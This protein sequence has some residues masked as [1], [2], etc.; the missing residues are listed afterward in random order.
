MGR[1]SLLKALLGS[2]FSMAHVSKAGISRRWDFS[3]P[4]MATTFRI[5]CYTEDKAAAERA[6]EACFQ[7]IA[8]LNAV[9]TDYDPTSELMRLCA[10]ETKQPAAVST[11]LFD[12]LSR[13]RQIAE[14]TG[15]AFD[16]TCGHLSHL[17]RRAKRLSQLPPADRLEKARAVTDWRRITLHAETRR[18]SL[19]SGTLLDLGGIAKGYAA[20]ACLRLLR[21]HGI[22]RAVVLAGGDT[23]A[24]EPPP[25]ESGWQIT[26]RT[27]SQQESTVKLSRR[28]VSTSGDLH[29]F[30]E[31]GGVRYSHILSP[32]TGLGLTQRIACS[33]F[34]P[35][36]TTSDALA[37]A[38]CV[39]GKEKGHLLVQTLPAIEVRFAEPAP[40]SP[41]NQPSLR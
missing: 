26:L 5:A 38:M 32:H 25:G 23:A 20:D 14:Q 3:G 9:F 16:P 2:S 18:V 36:C 39:M 31:I 28:S 41:P 30:T 6:T 13:A 19:V 7:R 35:D 21:E 4:G 29:Q 33:V 10:P 8:K 15:G 34:A 22:D 11:D 1:R 27:D 12:I 37:T 24:G 17:W 40:H